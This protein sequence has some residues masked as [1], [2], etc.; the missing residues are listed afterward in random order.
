MAESSGGTQSDPSG[1]GTQPDP[2]GGGMQSESST[3]IDEVNSKGKKV[4]AWYV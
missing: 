3:D 4:S 1:G 2:T